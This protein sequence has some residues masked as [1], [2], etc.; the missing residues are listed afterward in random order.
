MLFLK[1]G[2]NRKNEYKWYIDRVLYVSMINCWIK[3]YFG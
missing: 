1:E 3:A 2:I